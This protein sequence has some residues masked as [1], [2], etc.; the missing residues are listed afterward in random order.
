MTP[1]LTAE[2]REALNQTDGP[3]PV[4]DGETQRLYFLIDESRLNALEEHEDLTA[5]REGIADMEAGR[6]VSLDELDVRI[7]ARLS[8]PAKK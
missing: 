2:Q 7:R 1:K 4:E 8:L 3:V 5:I 6:V